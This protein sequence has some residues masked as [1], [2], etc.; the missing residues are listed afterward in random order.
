M[1]YEITELN[2]ENEQEYKNF[3]LKHNSPIEFE[4]E[5]RKLIESN[6]GFKAI[7]LIAKK[8]DNADRN[9]GIAAVLPLFE[10]NSFLFGKRLIS[11][12]I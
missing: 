10:A 7:Y 8:K 3:I 9:G 11:T 1:D 2:E 4:P 5:W 12:P 6:F